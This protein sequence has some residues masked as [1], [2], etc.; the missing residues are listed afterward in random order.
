[1]NVAQALQLVARTEFRPF[2]AADFDG[3]AGVENENAM[4]GENGDYVII[5]D[6]ETIYFQTDGDAP[7]W[8]TFSV[9]EA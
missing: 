9:N 2:D 5:I 7:D 8:F 6:G 3:F 4:I 1:M